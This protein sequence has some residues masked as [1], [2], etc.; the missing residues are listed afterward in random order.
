MHHPAQFTRGVDAVKHPLV[1]DVPHLDDV[2]DGVFQIRRQD[3]DHHRLD[4]HHGPSGHHGQ[5]QLDI[6]LQLG[7]LLVHR[8]EVEGLAVQQASL[9][10]KRKREHRREIRTR[11]GVTARHLHKH[12]HIFKRVRHDHL[13]SH[14]LAFRHIQ[15]RRRKA[16][17]HG[18]QPSA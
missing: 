16:H 1:V 5:G 17:N 13:H 18:A 9:K 14:T 12:L 10:L 3:V 7:V 8:H 2:V 4:A 11:L 6:L 15:L